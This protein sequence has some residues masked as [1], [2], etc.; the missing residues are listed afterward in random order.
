MQ[1][2]SRGA[3]YILTQA[4]TTR[5]DCLICHLRCRPGYG[6]PGQRAAEDHE[7]ASNAVNAGA[8]WAASSYRWNYRGELARRGAV[9]A[10]SVGPGVLGDR[11]ASFDS[12]LLVAYFGTCEEPGPCTQMAAAGGPAASL[13]ASSE[14]PQAGGSGIR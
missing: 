5:F 7:G 13:D 11:V 3:S 6:W 4:R 2:V 8:S 9:E 1:C 14:R 10:N 12:S